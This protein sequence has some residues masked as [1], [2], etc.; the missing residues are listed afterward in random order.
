MEIKT[1]DTSKE[2]SDKQGS[3]SGTGKVGYGPFSLSVTV[4]G[5]VSAHKENTRS[6]DKS[7]KY[8]VEVKATDHGMP[9]GLARVL[10]IMNRAIVPA[11]GT[12]SSQPA[13][14]PPK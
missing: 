5:S 3:F 14:T 13:P 10:D 8:H 12:P 7:A 2:S 4:S 1:S 6:T 9:E 11:G